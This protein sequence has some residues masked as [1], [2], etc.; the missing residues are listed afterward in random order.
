MN[1]LWVVIGFS[2]L[3]LWVSILIRLRRNH[4]LKQQQASENQTASTP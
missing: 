3:N 4:R 2:V 1:G